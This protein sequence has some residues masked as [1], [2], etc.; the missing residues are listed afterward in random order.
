MFWYGAGGSWTLGQHDKRSVC[1]V[2]IDR[3]PC[4]AHR[5]GLYRGGAGRAA[6]VES[7]R[8]TEPISAVRRGAGKTQAR[9]RASKVTHTL[10]EHS[11]TC[12]KEPS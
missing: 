7:T 3:A 1:G 11:G 9:L 2:A 12:G 5:R 8:I 6:G 4:D 10:H